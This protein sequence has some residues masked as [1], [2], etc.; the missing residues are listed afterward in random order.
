[1]SKNAGQGVVDG[2]CWHRFDRLDE[3][4]QHMNKNEALWR[5]RGAWSDTLH[6]TWPEAGAFSGHC[7]VCQAPASL[8]YTP[9]AD[10]VNVREA[11]VCSGCQLNARQRAVWSA[12]EMAIGTNRRTGIYLTEQATPFYK[13]VKNKWPMTKGSEYFPKETI[14]RLSAYIKHLVGQQEVLRWEDICKLSLKTRSVDGIVCLEV[15]EH[16]PNYSAA[17]LEFARVLKPGGCLIVTVPFL[18]NTQNTLVRARINEQGQ[19]EHLAPPEYH[20]DPVD[21]EGILAYYH[22]GWDLLD[23]LRACG[24]SRAQW[25]VPWAPHLGLF[26]RLW[27]LI[28][29]R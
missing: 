17:L 12:M 24:F 2:V 6:H 27:T 3:Y 10:V 13:A 7:G 16:V 14:E 21:G 18:D 26:S 28:A 23:E 11:L 20:G 29:I 5:H 1:M 8:T 4:Q 25:C 9:N 22:F 15:L 19:V